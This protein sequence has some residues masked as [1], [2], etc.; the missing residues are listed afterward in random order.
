MTQLKDKRNVTKKLFGMVCAFVALFT[1]VAIGK[2]TAKAAEND[3]ATKE[4]GYTLTYDYSDGRPVKT[5]SGLTKIPDE[6]EIPTKE[7]YTFFRWSPS[8]DSSQGSV[9]GGA[10]LNRDT[11]IYAI[12]QK[13]SEDGIVYDLHYGGQSYKLRSMSYYNGDVDELKNYV[14]PDTFD[15]LPITELGLDS[16]LSFRNKIETLTIGKN[17]ERISQIFDWDGSESL[18]SV[19]IPNSVTSIDGGTFEKCTALTEVTIPA[20]VGKIYHNTFNGCT[21]LKTVR[22][23]GVITQVG[24]NAFL[25][26]TSLETIYY[27]G[28]EA[29]WENK[30]SHEYD[31][32][33]YYHSIE[34][35]KDWNTGA[36]PFKVE[37]ENKYFIVDF[38]KN[39]DNRYPNNMSKYMVVENGKSIS[40]PATPTLPSYY[41]YT[42]EGWYKD[43]DC[44]QKWD[45]NTDVVTDDTTLYAGWD[46]G[47][48]NITF[49]YGGKGTNYTTSAVKGNLI[50]KP[51]DPTAE[52]Y[53]FEGWFIDEAC[54]KEWDFAKDTVTDN[55]TLYAKWTKV[56]TKP[57]EPKPEEPKPEEPKPEEPKPEEPKPE[58]PK[59]E[60]PKPEEPKQDTSTPSTPAEDV[61]D[62]SKPDKKP[63]A[64]VE[65]D[66]DGNTM[67]TTKVTDEATGDVVTKTVINEVASDEEYVVRHK[68]DK[69]GTVKSLTVRNYTKS[70]TITKSKA[71]RAETL[72]NKKDVPLT[73]VVRDENGKLVYKVRINTKNVKKNT[74]LQVYR[75]DEKTKT[76]HKVKKAYQTIK[77]DENANITCE[78]KKL[79]SNQRYVLVTKSQAKK[80]EKKIAKAKAAKK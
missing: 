61:P 26:C 52:G 56:E 11:T 62:A 72:A 4:E 13:R 43:A 36:A 79:A 27:A 53:K 48:K 2:V 22:I 31:W 37:F 10:E 16:F 17:V 78:F 59:P 57:E 46:N 69:E 68:E 20:G 12:W 29:Q 28:T 19:I 45:F 5:E 39:I 8:P 66:K 14:I 34:F 49:D 76:Y 6:L 73:V 9:S 32:Q 23:E 80:I 24:H 50:S 41:G 33:N 7:G 65:T 77:S 58:E 60:E 71:D 25:D 55:I 1:L 70:A 35:G 15:G 3:D 64:V 38:E 75:Y 54:T 51:S 63:D 47:K 21:A 40:E 42:F 67:T 18:K 74:T 30:L 44:T